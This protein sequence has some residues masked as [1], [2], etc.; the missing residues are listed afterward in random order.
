MSFTNMNSTIMENFKFIMHKYNFTYQNWFGLLNI[1]L[2][3]I[4]CYVIK[5]GSTD[6]ICIVTAIR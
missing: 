1:I 5:C 4:E 3:K 2:K 6:D